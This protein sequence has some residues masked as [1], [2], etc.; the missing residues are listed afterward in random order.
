[1]VVAYGIRLPTRTNRVFESSSGINAYYNHCL[2]CVVFFFIWYFTVLPKARLYMVE[3]WIRMDLRKQSGPTSRYYPD[4]F[5][6]RMRKTTKDRQDRWCHARDSNLERYRHVNPF[7]S[8]HVESFCVEVQGFHFVTLPC[9]RKPCLIP[10]YTQFSSRFPSTFAVS[11]I[12]DP[13]FIP[14]PAY[15]RISKRI[16]EGFCLLGCNAV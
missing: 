1:M 6:G 16:I 5:L 13:G 2:V 10:R 9:H 14:I 12:E 8:W 4:I 3:W 15:L 11:K 7:C